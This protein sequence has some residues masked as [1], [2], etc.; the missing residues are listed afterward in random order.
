VDA[1]GEKAWKSS[2]KLRPFRKHSGSLYQVAIPMNS[3]L[4][5]SSQES[6]VHLHARFALTLLTPAKTTPIE[7]SVAPG[8]PSEPDELGGI[9]GGAV[10]WSFVS[11]GEKL[12]MIPRA[13]SGPCGVAEH[14]RFVFMVACLEPLHRPA[15]MSLADGDPEAAGSPVHWSGSGSGLSV[16]RTATA[17]R[18]PNRGPGVA[19]KVREAASHFVVDLDLPNFPLT[20]CPLDLSPEASFSFST[21]WGDLF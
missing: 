12:R 16:W 9:A 15:R 17:M 10:G 21:G 20:R 3:A 5:Q 18:M 6:A 1:A 4:W 13:G 7:T 2:W 8:P 11:G 14:Q 19:V